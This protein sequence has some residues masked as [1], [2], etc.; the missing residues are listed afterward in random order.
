MITDTDIFIDIT[1]VSLWRCGTEDDPTL[2]KVRT[3]PVPPLNRVDIRV[4]GTGRVHPNGGGVSVFDNINPTLK[5]GFW[6]KIPKGTRIPQGLYIRRD[7]EHL[8]KDIV[9]Y[10]ICPAIPISL[11]HFR[12]LLLQLSAK[13]E[14]VM[15]A[16]EVIR[17]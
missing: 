4:D 14:R 5:R 10:S 3:K 17:K 12:M 9:H 15:A 7:A 2:A 11:A 1:P 16:S 6:W 8:G 13:A